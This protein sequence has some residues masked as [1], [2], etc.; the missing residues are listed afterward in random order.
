MAYK[1]Q[2]LQIKGI[3]ESVSNAFEI[4]IITQSV[5]ENVSEASDQIQSVQKTLVLIKQ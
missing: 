4:A 5:E 2:L 3:L 1:V